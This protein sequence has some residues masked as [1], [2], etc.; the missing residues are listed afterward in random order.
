M[1]SLLLWKEHLK[2]F[3]NRYS[4]AVQPVIRF[5]FALCTFL[6]LNANIGY[7]NKLKNPLVVILVCLVSA[8]LPY[9]AIVFLAGCLL[10][11][12]VYAVSLEMALITLVL[13][14]T[15]A[16]LYYG[17]KPGDS[18]L[19]VLTPLA[20]LFKIP[21]AVPLLVGL[22]GSLASVIPVGCG[23]F[24]YYLIMYVKQNAG[25]LTNDAAVDIVQKYSQILKSVIFN[26]T[27]MVMIATCAVGIII[28][29]LIRRLSM[30]YSW[31]V[32]IAAGSVAELL[33]IFVGDF[34]FGVTVAVGQLILGI[35]LSAVIAAVYNF[36]IFT[37]DYTRTE[38]VQF[39]DDDYYY[40]VKAVPKMNVS[41]PDVKVQK[42][43]TRKRSTRE[44]NVY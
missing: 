36:F 12:H 18:Y 30:D 14:L 33:V 16:I 38:H 40:Y 8:L 11:A 37:V 39:E 15:V 32:A 7:M 5:L 35:L 43:S 20:F 9:G 24:L 31:I 2:S 4:Y 21:Y 13:I 44:R 10:V 27:M 1:T 3:Y 25:V 28:V 22:G 42:I 23:V 41:T 34:V 29:Y 19:I 17:F 6:S 26:Q